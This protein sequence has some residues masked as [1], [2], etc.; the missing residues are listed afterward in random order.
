M[1]PAV[2]FELDA[3]GIATITLNRP[4]LRNPISGDDV[5]DGLCDTL[6][7]KGVFCRVANF[8]G[9]R[10]SMLDVNATN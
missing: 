8:G 4:D 3:S 7:A 9:E 10:L 1:E 5:V 2:L 6:A